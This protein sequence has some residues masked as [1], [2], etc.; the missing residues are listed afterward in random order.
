MYEDCY[1]VGNKL[2]FVFGKAYEDV[3]YG[4]Q[5]SHPIDDK[6]YYDIEIHLFDLSYVK[7]EGLFDKPK[8]H[9]TYGYYNYPESV[10]RI[11]EHCAGSYKKVEACID[12][13]ALGTP[14][15][16]LFRST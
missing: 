5:K 1:V 14:R 4:K 12:N 3:Y 8:S 15:V 7:C 9:F 10:V 2:V 13:M 11:Y 6:S 16:Y